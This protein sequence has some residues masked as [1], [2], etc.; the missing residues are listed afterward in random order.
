MTAPTNSASTDG[1]ARGI[2]DDV[3]AE[4]NV[5]AMFGGQHGEGGSHCGAGFHRASASDTGVAPRGAEVVVFDVG[6]GGVGIKG[7]EA[8]GSGGV[9]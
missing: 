7:R 5:T 8:V 6:A 1:T 2:G 9:Y 4:R 3:K